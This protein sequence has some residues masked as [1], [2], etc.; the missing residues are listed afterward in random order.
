MKRKE[1]EYDR[2]K[3]DDR[4]HDAIAIREEIVKLQQK[5]SV[6]PQLL[7]RWKGES[8]QLTLQ[9]MQEKLVDSVGT[10]KVRKNDKSLTSVVGVYR[11]VLRNEI[12]FNCQEKSPRGFGCPETSHSKVRRKGFAETRYENLLKGTEK[13]ESPF[14]LPQNQE[15]SES[16]SD[17]EEE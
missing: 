7:E 12:V 4:L 16:E 13:F 8:E 15:G 17:E 6:T 9:R 1:E 5:C 14:V 11:G 10:R 3:S 2:A